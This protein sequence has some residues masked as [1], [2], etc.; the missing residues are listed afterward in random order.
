MNNRSNDNSRRKNTKT[1]D[2]PKNW[3]CGAFT[4]SHY[5]IFFFVCQYVKLHKKTAENSAVY[6]K[7]PYIISFFGEF[8]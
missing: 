5:I 6:T 4:A 7:I 3:R 1:L 2:K 8:H